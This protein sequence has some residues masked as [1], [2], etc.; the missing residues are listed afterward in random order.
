[1]HLNNA[2]FS[3]NGGCGFVLK[4]KIL[5]EPSLNFD[6]NDLHTMK[7]AII[8]AITVISAQKLP[9]NDDL[10]DDV[11]DPYVVVSVHGVPK[12]CTEMKTKSVKD[13]GFNPR[14]E[15]QKPFEFYVNCPDLAI[16]KFVIKDDD[17]GKDQIIGHYSIRLS[18]V[19][20]GKNLFI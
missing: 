7:N 3:D 5:L 4:P 18:N 15:N 1:M 20:E 13:N 2:L 12:D 16:V 10:A 17:L 19:K 14:W 6:P 9:Q 11:S 8:L